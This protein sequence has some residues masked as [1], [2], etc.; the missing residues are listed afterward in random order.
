MRTNIFLDDGLVKEGLK[1]TKLKTKKELVNLALKEL[2]ERR[3]RKK[4]LKLEG[5]IV[6]EGNLDKMR[7]SRFDTG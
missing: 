3:K 7:R 4:I 5:K 2:V 1:L 6:W